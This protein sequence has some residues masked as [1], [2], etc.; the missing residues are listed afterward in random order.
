MS[1]QERCSSPLIILMASSGSALTSPCPSYTR[2]PEAE[3]STAGWDLTRVEYMGTI[4][5]LTV[6]SKLLSVQLKIQLSFW[7]QVHVSS[8]CWGCFFLI[9]FLPPRSS[10][11]KSFTWWLLSIHFPPSLYLCL[12]LPQPGCRT[13]HLALLNFIRFEQAHLSR[14]SKSL[15]MAS[16]PSTV[17]WLHHS[18]ECSL[19]T[20]LKVQSIPLFT[21]LTKMLNC[22]SP[23]RDTTCHWS[24]P[25]HDHNSEC[26][27]PANSLSTQWSIRQIHVSSAETRMPCGVVS[28][29]FYKSK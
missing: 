5:S 14:L 18:V 21:S 19:Q 26:D 17:S 27:H 15:W 8:F 12:E 13:L 29:A 1:S 10:L 28:N 7:V 4:T 9:D 23:L 16:I 25:R 22:A 24:P 3:C 11:P 2:A 20:F 6:L